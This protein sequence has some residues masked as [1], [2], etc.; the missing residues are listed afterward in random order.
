M[1]AA[2][3]AARLMAEHLA[4]LERLIAAAEAAIPEKEP[5]R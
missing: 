5:T 1:T 3:Y 2:D 4:V